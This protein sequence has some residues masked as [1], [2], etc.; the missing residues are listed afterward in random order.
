MERVEPHVLEGEQIMKRTAAVSIAMGGLLLVATSCGGD[1]SSSGSAVAKQPTVSIA[2]DDDPWGVNPTWIGYVDGDSGVIDCTPGG[3][4]YSVWGDKVYTG[5]SSI[6]TAAVYEGL[7]TFE[8]GGA[9]E[10]KVSEGRDS[11]DS[12]DANGV[13]TSEYGEWGVSFTLVK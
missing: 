5:D 6:C 11:Y 7:I 10:F 9:V 12:G 13:V 3:T 2:E 8:K 1:D 4:A